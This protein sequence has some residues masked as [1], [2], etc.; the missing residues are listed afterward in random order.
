[1]SYPKFSEFAKDD[2]RLEGPKKRID[3]VLS[4]DLLV[5]GY[6]IGKSQYT[7]KN[8]NPDAKYLTLQIEINSVKFIIFTGSQ[9]LI[10]Q[11]EKYADK[12]PF[13][14]KIVKIDRYYSLS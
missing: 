14:A 1:M 2:K 9:V 8:K 10:E 13:L 12:M 5:T 11:V 4:I 7:D 6:R 3:E